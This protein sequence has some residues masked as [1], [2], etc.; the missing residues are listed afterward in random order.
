MTRRAKGSGRSAR[1]AASSD[2]R[3]QPKSRRPLPPRLV[4]KH[5]LQHLLASG[6]RHATSKPRPR[7]YS[8]SSVGL[9]VIFSRFCCARAMADHAAAP[10]SPAMNSRRRIDL[11][12]SYCLDG[13]P[14]P[15]LHVW[16]G[17]EAEFADLFLQRGRPVLGPNRQFAASQPYVRSRG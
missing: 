9:Q 11:P 12:S 15:V 2:A 6:P 16:S 3:H 10:P 4:Q 8:S 13:L 7:R 17:L 14:R 5:T 1:T